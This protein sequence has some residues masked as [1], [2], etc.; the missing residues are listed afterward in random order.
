MGSTATP[1]EMPEHMV[2]V[3]GFWI[4]QTEV[5]NAEYARCV[6]AQA[7]TPPANQRWN[8]PAYAKH[9]VTNVN[10]GQ[11]NQYAGWAGGRLPTEAEWEKAARGTDQRSYP[12]G[13]TPIQ[14]DLLNYN[15]VK[16]DTMPVGSY[17]AGASPYGALDMAGNVE[18]WVTDWYSATY[19]ASSP[20]QNPLGPATGV[21]FRVT[22]G[23]SY[24]SRRDD[25]RTTVR[26]KTLLGGLGFPTVGF[27][28]VIPKF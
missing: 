19:Y 28:V 14:D 15:D 3:D 18:E 7:C 1:A 5:T 4:M 21:R 20:A 22:R 17:P 23:G 9:P 11:A 12:W 25:V 6:T 10:W 8:D 26:G 24:G 16:R 2:D 27:R 13:N